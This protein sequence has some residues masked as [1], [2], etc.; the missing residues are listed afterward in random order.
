MNDLNVYE[1]LSCGRTFMT[2][3]EVDGC[4]MCE[5]LKRENNKIEENS[6]ENITNIKL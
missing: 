3:V 2:F 1:C 6:N 4:I 5:S